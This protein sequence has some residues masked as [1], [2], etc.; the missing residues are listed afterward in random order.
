MRLSLAG[1]QKNS[2]A[3]ELARSIATGGSS[4]IPARSTP[5]S[6]PEAQA[7]KRKV[8]TSN[9]CV[10]FRFAKAV[11]RLISGTTG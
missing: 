11:S 5:Q 8:D 1:Q 2:E 7:L 3:K 9:F 10:L 6:E 4:P